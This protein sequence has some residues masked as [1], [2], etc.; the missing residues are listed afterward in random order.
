ML[1][2]LVRAEV[3]VRNRVPCVTK[4]TSATLWRLNYSSVKP[5]AFW[6]LEGGKGELLQVWETPVQVLGGPE[7]EPDSSGAS[8]V[9]MK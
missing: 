3:F 5:L 1:H 4:T 2:D 8:W 6:C 7:A 9:S